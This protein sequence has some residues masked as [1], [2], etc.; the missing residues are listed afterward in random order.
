[1][2]LTI[3]GFHIDDFKL[4]FDFA[5]AVSS[6][7]S[8]TS[9]LIELAKRALGFRKR[10]DLINI[11]D[12]TL[13]DSDAREQFE[14]VIGDAIDQHDFDRFIRQ[15]SAANGEEGEE[16][17]QGAGA[18]AGAPTQQNLTQSTCECFSKVKAFFRRA[19]SGLATAVAHGKDLAAAKSRAVSTNSSFQK[20]LASFTY[21]SLMI[22]PAVL[23]RLNIDPADLATVVTASAIQES[24]L[25]STVRS[26]IDEHATA[27]LE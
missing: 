14:R 15:A 11:V 10:R 26:K 3:L 2:D 5:N 6:F 12:K 24:V 19:A 22:D 13:L 9:S 27:V 18:G 25:V 7:A 8:L 4:E 20:E 16:V 1:M 23:S 17:E 21:D